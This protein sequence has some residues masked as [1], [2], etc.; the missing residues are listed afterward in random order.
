MKPSLDAREGR[1][2]LADEIHRHIQ[3]DPDGDCRQRIR[4]IMDAWNGERN[5]QG[6]ACGKRAKLRAALFGYDLCRAEIRAT[7]S[8]SDRP[9]V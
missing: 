3:L 4:D 8:V 1:Q 6:F 2:R 9:Y 7:P 5:D